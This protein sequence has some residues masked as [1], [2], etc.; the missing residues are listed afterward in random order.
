MVYAPSLKLRK[1]KLDRPWASN[2][3]IVRRDH[4]SRA[5]YRAF[6]YL[7]SIQNLSRPMVKLPNAIFQN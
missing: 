5:A 2:P 3:P 4:F 7:F 1:E 6:H